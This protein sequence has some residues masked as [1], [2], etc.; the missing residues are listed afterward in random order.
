MSLKC[1]E[2][3]KRNV[4]QANYC[5]R[6]KHRFTPKEKEAMRLNGFWSMINWVKN[7]WDNSLPGKLMD[8]FVVK[9][10]IVIIPLVGGVWFF[11]QNGSAL[12]IEES[13]EYTRQYNVETDDYYLLLSQ[14]KSKLNLYLPHEIEH[15]YVK[16]YSEG[17]ELLEEN[18]YDDLDD[19]EVTVNNRNEHNYYVIGITEEERPEDRVKVYVYRESQVEYRAEAKEPESEREPDEEP[20]KEPAEETKP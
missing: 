1:P 15:F 20:A 4:S 7:T 2:C 8:S 16:Y 14:E 11:M 6:C 18:S 9:L 3:K 10:I 13:E 19:V 17:G 5:R 12:K